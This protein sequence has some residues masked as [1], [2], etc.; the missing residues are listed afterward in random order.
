[1]PIV[2]I[3]VLLLYHSIC[4]FQVSTRICVYQDVLH[5]AAFNS[6]QTPGLPVDLVSRECDLFT[7]ILKGCF[8]DNI[9]HSAREVTLEDMR[10]THNNI[11]LYFALM[12]NN[13]W[14]YFALMPPPPPHPH[15]TSPSI[16]LFVPP[17]LYRSLYLCN[18]YTHLGT[19]CSKIVINTQTFQWRK[20]AWNVVCK[21]L[22][23]LFW[24]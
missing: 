10:E 4:V 23:I 5:L 19:N 2:V 17:S 9:C 20:R 13:I 7:N 6:R 14:L 11:W 3:V 8:T 15:P 12:P 24:P 18:V 21:M 16:S 22:T 1:M